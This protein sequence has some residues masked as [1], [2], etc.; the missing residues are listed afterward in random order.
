MGTAH[1]GVWYGLC[2]QSSRISRKHLG[3]RQNCHSESCYSF[4]TSLRTSK[5]VIDYLLSKSSDPSHHPS[6]YDTLTTV[7]SDL[8]LIERERERKRRKHVQLRDATESEREELRAK[9]DRKLERLPPDGE[10]RGRRKTL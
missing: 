8:A 6:S 4:F 2:T 1:K 7:A 10:P 9:L 5:R 3:A